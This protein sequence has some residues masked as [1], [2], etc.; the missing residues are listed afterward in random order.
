M[1]DRLMTIARAHFT[2]AFKLNDSKPQGASDHYSGGA[3]TSR[4]NYS[5]S[6]KPFFAAKNQQ[7]IDDLAVFGLKW[8]SNLDAA[9]RAWK[10]EMRK[11]HPDHFAGDREKSKAANELAQFYNAAYDRLKAHY[12]KAT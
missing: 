3:G 6:N 12:E 5:R 10:S 1:L 9:T 7:V 8:P 2:N 11:Y 4:G